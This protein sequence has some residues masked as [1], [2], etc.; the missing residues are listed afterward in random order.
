M[1]KFNVGVLGIG[2][3]SDVYINNLKKYNIINVVACAGRNLQKAQEKA[4]AHAL[5]KAY[6]TPA[7]LVA[8]A[9]VDI[10]L[11]LTLPAVHAE[12]NIMALEAGK[13]VYT[14]KPLAATFKEGEQLLALAQKRG[15]SVGCAPDTFLGGRLQTCRQLIDEG[16]I[17]EVTGASAFV[18]S[19]G[20]EWF[21]PNPDFF[22]KPG[23]G[24]LLDIGPYY[25]TALVSL[26]GAAKRCCAMSKRT[27]ATRVIESRPNKGKTIDVEVDTHIS[28]N[29]EF[30][31]GAIAT[32]IASFDVWDS[33]LPRLEIYGTKGTICIRDIDPLDGPNLFGG[34]VLL[35]TVDNYRWKGMPRQT[36]YSEW[37]EAPSDHRFN[38]TSHRENSRGIGLVDMA[39]AIRDR[40]PERASG[41][42]ALHCLEIMESLLASASEGR[43]YHLK[44]SC[45]RPEPLSVNFPESES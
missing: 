35:R 9:N 24:P 32:L 25:V 43:F 13:H 15:L 37:T 16:Q 44:S 40:R 27:F 22:Y 26:L 6:A 20:H 5:A 10:I 36:P 4:A 21:H 14:E 18:V 8:D 41:P 33:E 3:I 38:E 7:E 45:S 31:N 23:G 28:G 11:N 30:T 2:D 39:Y 1:K 29:I 17:G 12:L 34:P 19:H 42:M